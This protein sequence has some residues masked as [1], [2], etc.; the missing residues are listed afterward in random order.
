MNLANSE[1]LRFR[2]SGGG[3]TDANAVVL[4]HRTPIDFSKYTTFTITHAIS[5]QHGSYP[6]TA[7]VGIVSTKLDS[8]TAYATSTLRNMFTKSLIDTR[9]SFNQKTDTVDVSDVNISGYLVISA[10]FI[11]AGYSGDWNIYNAYLT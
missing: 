1:R 5:L 3:G 4:T 10:N 7:M 2:G 9:A 6:M 11:T 8:N